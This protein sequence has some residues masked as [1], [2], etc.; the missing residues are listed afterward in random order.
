VLDP[1]CS[2]GSGPLYAR[3]V[4]VVD[5]SLFSGVDHTQIG[6][7]EFSGLEFGYAFTC[8]DDLCLTRAEGCVFLSNRTP[9]DGPL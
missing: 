6:G 4:V 7:S 1:F 8:G 3:F 9:G 5:W 2:Y